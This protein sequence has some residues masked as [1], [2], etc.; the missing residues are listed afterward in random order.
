MRGRKSIK[1]D[2]HNG[3]IKVVCNVGT[4]TTGVDWDVRCI[5]M[6]RPTK[7]DMLFVQIV[8]RGL[9][10]ADG[11][12]HC[13]IL[14]HSDN[15]AR[16]GFVTDIDESYTGLHDGKT[17]THENR[18]EGIRLPKECPKCAYLK[19]P[20]TALCPACG[21]VAKVVSHIKPDPGEL[22]ELKRKPRPKAEEGVPTTQED[23][24]AFYAELKGYG[25]LH[26]YKPGWA[27]N[28]YRERIGTWP[29]WDMKH[30]A[31]RTPR[32]VTAS[33]IRSRAIAWARRSDGD[34]RSG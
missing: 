27:A 29:A 32:A 34:A 22:R 11:K 8:G 30:V 18:T 33:W 21:F 5:S 19:P 3:S 9:R 4:L 1:R 26:G 31:P 10:T 6:C 14:D 12:D 7:S 17:P 28:K 23:K 20:K 15:H 2:F 16:L 13:L 25:M 24:A